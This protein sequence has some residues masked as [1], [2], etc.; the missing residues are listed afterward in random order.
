MTQWIITSSVLIVII[1]VL[2]FVLRG[3]ISLKLQYALWGL[4]LIRLLL[5]FSVFESPASVLNLLQKREETV[6][7]PAIYEPYEPETVTPVTP[8]VPDEDIFILDDNIEHIEPETN[9]TVDDEGFVTEPEIRVISAKD[10]LIP[11]WIGG[12]AVFGAVFVVSNLRFRKKLKNTREYLSETKAWLPVY[13][14]SAVKTPCLFG[15]IKPAIYVTE[16]VLKDE[17]TIC[18]V[19]EHETT[20]YRHGDHIWS[21][22]RCFCLALHWYNPLVWLAAFLSMRDSEL[23][24][25]E[26]T[27]KRIGEDE[28]IGY[29][30]TL[31]N[32]TCEKP[33]VGIL[34]AATTMTGSKSSI[35]ERILLIAKKPK[36]LWITAVLVAVVAIFAVGC[37]FTGAKDA[38]EMKEDKKVVVESSIEGNENIVPVLYYEKGVGGPSYKTNTLLINDN[39]AFIMENHNRTFERT[40]PSSAYERFKENEAVYGEYGQ[41]M[42]YYNSVFGEIFL[43]ESYDERVFTIV[44][45]NIKTEINFNEGETYFDFLYFDGNYYLFTLTETSVLRTYKISENLEVEKPFDFKYGNLDIDETVFIDN[46]V[47]IVG[48]NLVLTSE[49]DLVICNF[50]TNVTKVLPMDYS[51]FGM[52][53]DKDCFYVISYSDLGEIVFEKFSPEGESLGKNEIFLPSGFNYSPW[54]SRTD[55]TYY[56]YG[57]E[58]Y[59]E[60]HTGGECY[61]FSYDVE[62]EEW[63]N[64]WVVG[65]EKEP[66][67]ASNIKYMVMSGETY[68]DIFP[69]WSNKENNNTN[70]DVVSEEVENNKTYWE[71]A[72]AM[73]SKLPWFEFEFDF[74]FSLINVGVYTTEGQGSLYD[75]H[76]GEDYNTLALKNGDFIRWVPYI[77][78]SGLNFAQ[79]ATVNFVVYQ[80][81]DVYNYT[82]TGSLKI[83]QL[84]N[85]NGK[86]LY[87]ATLISESLGLFQNEETGGA[88]ICIKQ[89]GNP[90]TEKGSDSEPEII[91]EHIVALNQFS[92]GTYGAE[93]EEDK[94]GTFLFREY[95]EYTP[96]LPDA[97]TFEKVTYGSEEKPMYNGYYLDP[98]ERT[99]QPV[100]NYSSK[101]EIHDYLG[102]YLAKDLFEYDYY[103]DNFVELDGKL[104]SAVGNIGNIGI[105][106]RNCEIISQTENEMVVYADIYYEYSKQTDGTTKIVFEKQNGN[107]IITFFGNVSN[108][109]K[110]KANEIYNSE[111]HSQYLKNINIRVI[112]H[113]D[114]TFEPM[115][116]HHPAYPEDFPSLA[117]IGYVPEEA[118]ALAWR[119]TVESGRITHDGALD[120]VVVIDKTHAIVLEPVEFTYAGGGVSYGFANTTYIDSEECGYVSVYGWITGT[121]TDYFSSAKMKNVISTQKGTPLTADEIERVSDAFVWANFEGGFA[122]VNPLSNLLLSNYSK[123][124]EMSAVPFLY[125]FPSGLLITDEAEFDDLKEL[126]ASYGHTV[127]EGTKIA[128]YPVPLHKIPKTMVNEMLEKYM[129]ITV[130]ELK[131]SDLYVL[132]ENSI[133]YMEK[134]GC[135]YSTASDSGGSS[136]VCTS[137]E[138]FPDGTVILYGENSIL[139]LKLHPDGSYKIYS[140]Q[141]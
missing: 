81:G 26:D 100:T 62:S 138:K 15:A 87:E 95:P 72:P 68:Y 65:K 106:Y 4:V 47:V 34:S 121:Y 97:V 20:H 94:Y 85:E 140:Y 120:Y 99:V 16:E 61:I 118:V 53:A 69:Y 64:S 58:I 29:G 131:H 21:V 122:Y 8:A 92:L 70:N 80:N 135:F 84:A 49:K 32:L 113:R 13:K 2:R 130:E 115:D 109:E 43:F 105:T 60:F 134:Y 57:S 3:K 76:T 117:N 46:S 59:M 103:M 56:M 104:Y 22:L 101:Q 88:I 89:D 112:S 39:K 136:F 98:F 123:P 139:T 75:I 27:I 78:D 102:K 114:G 55:G 126:W 28:R 38:S 5:P 71:C 96:D 111:A 133:Y 125:Y 66:F 54:I 52:V 110:N 119:N 127:R 86:T 1:A 25:D 128:D 9:I 40:Y 42:V 19:F 44:K 23:A 14:S 18:H 129:G 63:K 73:S 36:M 107:W 79:S 12:I 33:A 45:N 108:Y 116:N 35:K 31:I 93:F 17:K 50:E 82:H 24:C 30:R 67:S 141:R 10:I 91:A 41:L 137:G 48:N 6:A 7:P 11:L 83:K 77:G 90:F 124:E 51:V 74:D 37:T 132:A